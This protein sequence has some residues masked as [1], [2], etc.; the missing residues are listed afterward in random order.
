MK[1]TEEKQEKHPE[2]CSIKRCT[3]PDAFPQR[4]EN[5]RRSRRQANG[6]KTHSAHVSFD[7]TGRSSINAVNSMRGICV[8]LNHNSNPSSLFPSVTSFRSNK[9]VIRS[10]QYKPKTKHKTLQQVVLGTLRFQRTNLSRQ[11]KSIIKSAQ[12]TIQQV[13]NAS[14]GWKIVIRTNE[15]RKQS[16]VIFLKKPTCKPKAWVR[17]SAK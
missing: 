14:F 17:K 7:R 11:N 4:E 3:A 6:G 13:M 10:N 2:E 1:K 12:P 9:R 16:K 5:V 15:K 8:N